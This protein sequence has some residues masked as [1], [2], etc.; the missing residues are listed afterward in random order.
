MRNQPH[1]SSGIRATNK[2]LAKESLFDREINAKVTR[3]FLVEGQ[4]MG[5]CYQSEP[6]LIENETLDDALCK[7]C[8]FPVRGKIPWAR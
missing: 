3:R 1:K 4:F 5:H 7:K 2:A 8:V 6:V